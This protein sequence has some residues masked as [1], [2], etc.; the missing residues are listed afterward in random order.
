MITYA[1]IAE[2]SD[3]TSLPLIEIIR[4]LARSAGDSELARAEL[5]H[6]DS[7]HVEITSRKVAENLATSL[8]GE[9]LPFCCETTAEEHWRFS[10]PAEYL[11]RACLLS[12]LP[13]VRA[14]EEHKPLDAPRSNGA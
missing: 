10:L 6:G 12:H 2:L 14:R 8:V 5:M 7:G 4:A 3:K 9:G 1:Q 11:P 13:L